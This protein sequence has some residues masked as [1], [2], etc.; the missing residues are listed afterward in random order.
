M[1]I[2]IDGPS[3]SGKSTLAKQLAKELRFDYLDTGAHYRA[4][5]YWMAIKKQPLDSF[6]YEI[7]SDGGE[8][9][10]FVNGEDVSITIRTAEVA[11]QVSE[12][13]KRAEVR[14]ALTA[15]Q[16][17]YAKNRNVILD[18]RDVGSVVFPYAACKFF[19]IASSKVRAKRRYEE[20]IL[21]KLIDPKITSVEMIEKELLER[22]RIDSTR[23]IAPLVK[24]EGAIEIDTSSLSVHRVKRVMWKK[25]K[26]IRLYPYRRWK[27]RYFGEGFVNCHGFY[28]AVKAFT[29]CL[30]HLFYRFRFYGKE[31]IPVGKGVIAPNHA[32]FFDPPVAAA[33]F[34]E[35]LFY[36]AQDYLFRV[37]L[38]GPFITR[39]NAL[40]VKGDVTDKG[41]FQEVLT[42]VDE[43]R[44][45]MIFPEGERSF[46]NKLLP[47]K[48]GVAAVAFLTDAPVIPVYIDGCYEAWKRKQWLPK[49]YG[50]FTVI[51]GKP[52]FPREFSHIEGRKDQQK[53]LLEELKI[54][55]LALKNWFETGKQG[56]I[57]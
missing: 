37:P 40:S 33:A 13:S 14:E 6:I 50:R 34:S 7:A 29:H 57:P 28:L 24:P 10:Y 25:L 36:L 51:V 12:I 8:K 18:G 4:I 31:N 15:W 54:R 20:L 1:I 35:G 16:R 52:I 46:D 11:A 45:V 39:M 48:R 5:T 44:K 32:S 22:D 49:P 2:T 55:M 19:L 43:G 30:L 47:F 41:V 21:K 38:L 9:R 27:E 3:G 26:T 56:F 53:A 42:I 17:E 23:E